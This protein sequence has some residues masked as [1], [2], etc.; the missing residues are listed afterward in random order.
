MNNLWLLVIGM[1]LVTY[2]PRMIPMVFLKDIKLTPRLKRFLEFIPYTVLAC[3]IF[4]GI[5]TSVGSMFSAII[6]GIAAVLL[7]LRGCNLVLIVLGAILSVYVAE[8]V[9]RIIA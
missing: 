5:L 2:I 9:L 4:P 1:A 3:L 6:G 7:A 8:Q